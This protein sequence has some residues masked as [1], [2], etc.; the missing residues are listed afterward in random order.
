MRHLTEEVGRLRR[1]LSSVAS[2]ISGERLEDRSLVANN[3][4]S[5]MTGAALGSVDSTKVNARLKEIFKEKISSYREAVYLLT[6]FKIDLHSAEGGAGSQHP[7][8]RLRSVYAERPEDSLIFQWTESTSLEL[9]ET[10]FI[11]EHVD[12]KLL[13]LLRSSNSIPAF[14]ASVT[15]DLFEKQT[16][17]A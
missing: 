8:L 16:I 13:A 10:P 6:G 14:L 17:F 5:F 4:S 12:R 11:S 9:L 2:D 1:Q 7:R 15:L 3:D